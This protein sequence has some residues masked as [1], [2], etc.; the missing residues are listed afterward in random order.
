[1]CSRLKEEHLNLATRMY[2]QKWW[3]VH[4]FPYAEAL[5]EWHAVSLRYMVQQE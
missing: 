3:T 4:D 1:M 5:D 2:L